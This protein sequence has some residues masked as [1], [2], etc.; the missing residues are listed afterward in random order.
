VKKTIRRLSALIRNCPRSC[1]KLQ[2]LDIRVLL[3]GVMSVRLVFWKRR[4][5]V[6]NAGERPIATGNRGH[7][8]DTPHHEVSRPSFSP[9]AHSLAR[10][11]T[12]TAYTVEFEVQGIKVCM[13][14]PED[15]DSIVWREVVGSV[16]LA[17]VEA[18]SVA[19]PV[20][21]VTPTIPV[22]PVKKP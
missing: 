15:I 14:P 7:G 3:G 21:P 20:T 12:M 4:E 8:R 11:A 9:R 17:I 5:E 16:L 19:D 18:M 1:P 10:P 2:A 13:E 6:G 22:Q